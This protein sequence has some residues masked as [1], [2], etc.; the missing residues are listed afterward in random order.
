[1]S[2]PAARG[3][4]TLVELV[5]AI[6]IL[7]LLVSTAALAVGPAAPAPTPIEEARTRALHGGAVVFLQDSGSIS[8]FYPDGR[9]SG[10]GLDPLTGALS[11]A[12]ESSAPLGV[13]RAP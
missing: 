2:A 3:G 10:P 8:V 1:M 4:V 6:S 5:V 7:G 13:G 11:E 12:S 9:A